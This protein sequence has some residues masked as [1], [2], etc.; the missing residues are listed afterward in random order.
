MQGFMGK[1]AK[2]TSVRVNKASEEHLEVRCRLEAQEVGFGERL[3]ELFAGIPS[4]PVVKFWLFVAAEKGL[5]VMLL[6]V[7]CACCLDGSMRRNVYAEL[8]HQEPRH[9]DRQAVGKITNTMYGA[10]HAP[11]IWAGTLRGILSI[12]TSL[13]VLS[14]LLCVDTQCVVSPSSY[15]S[16]TSCG[17]PCGRSTT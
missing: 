3:D 1:T 5:S 2:V 12:L 8:P 14:I 9:G 11:Q 7:K 17:T 13:P 10:G 16:A 15:M 4:L 6:D